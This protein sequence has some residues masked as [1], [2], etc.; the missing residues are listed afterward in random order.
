M[1]I[2]IKLL[3]IQIVPMI[4]LG[5]AVNSIAIRIQTDEF[6]YRTESLLKTAVE[7]Y[8]DDTNY[9]KDIS[10]IDITV[11]EG[12]TRVSSSIENSIGTKASSEVIEK[13][14]KNKENY[15]FKNVD[16][17]GIDYCG[18]YKWTD[19]GMIFAGQ[20]KSSLSKLINTI[21]LI[22]TA[23]SFS[24]IIIFVCSAT[25]IINKIIKRIAEAQK[26]IEI[27][28]S[29]DL[30]QEINVYENAK[31]ELKL[32]CNDTAILQ[33]SLKS[34]VSDI[35]QNSDDLHSN[36]VLF[37]T[38]FEGITESIGNINV[39]V[40]EIAQGATHQADDTQAAA[41]EIDNLASVTE[42][43]SENSSNLKKSSED[44]T[45]EFDKV[46]V[47]LEETV[48]RSNKINEKLISVQSKND[49]TNDAISKIKE[50]VE[51][52]KDITAQTNLL[53]LN[54]SIEAAH[55]GDAGRG[56]AVVAEEIR[57]LSENCSKGTSLIEE[58]VKTIL[59][60]SSENSE[61]LELVVSLMKNQND[62]F[63]ELNNRF[64]SL[65]NNISEVDRVSDRVNESN[66]AIVK[67]KNTIV[68]V[69]SDLSA[70]SQENAASCEETSASI[71]MINRN[72]LD[73]SDA[74][75]KL[76][77]LAEN[78]KKSVDKFNI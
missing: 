3:L 37:K 41:L 4:I 21:V 29:G 17:N 73:C 6:Y 52:I 35:K 59:E 50:A 2:K 22:L 51:L 18:Y 26:N 27:L 77:N 74:V 62:S 70:I 78:L 34:I 68:N 49:E 24:I 63:Q 47:S 44:M 60:K 39:A 16:V 10:N 55:A 66:E 30:T 76:N 72:I 14:L 20:E 75:E 61:E 5:C 15:F 25:F 19:T 71:E 28:A 12:D 43:N 33:K 48:K 56:F 11:F 38:N 69:I 7:G 9:L 31:D 53:S 8:T 54:A 36:N 64:N 1:K 13:V 23:I 45:S 32:I 58:I 42:E 67:S 40:E 46:D 57:K 65:K